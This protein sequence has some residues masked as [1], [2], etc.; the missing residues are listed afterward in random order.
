M[1]T[2]EYK[3]ARVRQWLLADEKFQQETAE[4]IAALN[5]LGAEGWE[6]FST[7]PLPS[8][9]YIDFVL[10]LKRPLGAG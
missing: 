10:W 4:Q 7:H 1:Q 8:M 6:V 3:T 5:A 2:W 9:Q